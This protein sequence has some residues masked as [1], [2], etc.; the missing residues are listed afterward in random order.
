[1]TVQAFG[2]NAGVT[3]HSTV[4]T[5]FYKKWS[6][7][8]GAV[9]YKTP[10]NFLA[11]QQG[12]GTGNAMYS[13]GVLC[14]LPADIA[15]TGA[16]TPDAVEIKCQGDEN[17]A[18]DV[19]D[20]FV[21]QF[22]KADCPGG[23]AGTLK[24]TGN[25]CERFQE[26][27]PQIETSDGKHYAMKALRRQVSAGTTVQFA[28]SRKYTLVGAHK[29]IKDPEAGSAWCNVPTTTDDAGETIFAGKGT[30]MNAQKYADGCLEDTQGDTPPPS[31]PALPTESP[32]DA[33]TATPTTLAP[34]GTPTQTPTD[35]PT[36][37]PI[38][39]TP[40]TLAPTTLAPT[41]TP[42]NCVKVVTGTQTNNQGNVGFELNFGDGWVAWKPSTYYSQGSTVV[43]CFDVKPDVRGQNPTTDAWAG[44]V[45][46]SSDSGATYN[47]MYCTDCESG[48]G[49]AGQIV[50]DSGSSASAS[51]D[52]GAQTCFNQWCTFTYDPYCL[53]VLTGGSSSN[54]GSMA[55]EIDYGK[56]QGWEQLR[57]GASYNSGDTVVSQ[58]F[59]SKPSQVRGK[60]SSTNA[61]A[62]TLRSSNNH[63]A[64]YTDLTCTNCV[65]G[66]GDA[67]K[68]VF[69]GNEDG[70][71]MGAINCLNGAW[72]TMT[73][74]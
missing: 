33:P 69:D 68:F 13:H 57:A 3:C 12:E 1:V 55:L 30:S 19:C 14:S 52:Q 37:T 5:S 23:D 51:S 73:L 8:N 65:A 58:C 7:H 70:G 63:G 31:L 20:I 67:G 35:T 49:P 10:N 64:T 47:T 62:G 74:Q 53:Q 34:T 32:T 2:A 36:Q 21:F 46:F 40:T 41:V 45:S 39:G 48:S 17:D 24:A 66:T 11:E 9:F 25:W 59:T 71:S 29:G 16:D 72:C 22:F 18:N 56:G 6:W 28:V 15:D 4:A 60:G 50:F 61:W 42:P 43:E 54:D 27:A 38:T 44:A 26:A